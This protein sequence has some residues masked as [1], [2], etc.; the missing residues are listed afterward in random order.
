MKKTK[1]ADEF[2]KA[3]KLIE[4]VALKRKVPKNIAR[5]MGQQSENQLRE[6][7]EK[8]QG[9][10]VKAGLTV[11][12]LKKSLEGLSDKTQ[13]YIGKSGGDGFL[14]PVSLIKARGIFKDFQLG[15]RRKEG[16]AR[17]DE[18]GLALLIEW[19]DPQDGEVLP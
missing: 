8:V 10:R 7:F 5:M 1:K 2:K 18:A 9:P 16:D 6:K 4:K 3:A 15:L 19:A 12:D 14:Y 13:V 17:H 11:K